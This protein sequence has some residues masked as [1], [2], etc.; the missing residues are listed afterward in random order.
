MPNKKIST[1]L[2]IYCP[3]Y[4]I[5]DSI[6]KIPFA[7]LVN[8]P[9]DA[10]FIVNPDADLSF[11]NID[12]TTYQNNRK[13][14]HSV[15]PVSVYFDLQSALYLLCQKQ[16]ATSNISIVPFHEFIK[17]Q[18]FDLFTTM[19]NDEIFDLIALNSNRQKLVQTGKLS[20][21]ITNNSSILKQDTLE[22]VVFSNCTKYIVR[23]HR[24]QGIKY[25]TVIGGTGFDGNKVIYSTNIP[26]HQGIKKVLNQVFGRHFGFFQLEYCINIGKIEVHSLS[27]GLH[28]MVLTHGINLLE[29]R[30]VIDFI[31]GNYIFGS[32]INE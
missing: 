3:N 5:Y 6:S 17:N 29:T 27:L 20:D 32:N 23:R 30:T 13:K 26:I 28:P 25:N 24:T 12:I 1:S 15:E 31:A 9:Y 19:Y 22:D 18:S 10:D 2:K 14:I 11:E 8:N 7:Q 4:D 16:S 21:I